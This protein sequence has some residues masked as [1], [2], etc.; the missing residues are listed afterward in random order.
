MAGVDYFDTLIAIAD[1]CPVQA[2]TDPPADAANLSVAAR[3]FAMITG[4][5]YHYTSADVIFAVYADRAGIPEPDR[6]AARAEFYA[7]PQPCLRPRTA[8]ALVSG[9][10]RRYG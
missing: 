7:R 6:A 9:G 8:V 4:R 2:G 1:D 3:Q 10:G 5:P